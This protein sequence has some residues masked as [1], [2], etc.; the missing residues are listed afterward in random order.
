MCRACFTLFEQVDG[1]GSALLAAILMQMGEGGYMKLLMDG[2]KQSYVF[3]P[4]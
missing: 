4:G 2:G 3:D 1:H